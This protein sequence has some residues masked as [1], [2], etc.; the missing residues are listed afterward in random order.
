MGSSILDI[1]AWAQTLLFRS[2]YQGAFGFKFHHHSQNTST[3][4]STRWMMGCQAFFACLNGDLGIDRMGSVFCLT[5]G[6]SRRTR[7]LRL[8]DWKGRS[9]KGSRAA[10]RAA[11]TS[12][13]L[14]SRYR[15]LFGSSAWATSAQCDYATVSI[16]LLRGFWGQGDSS[17]S[18]SG[19]YG[20]SFHLA[21]KILF[22]S[23]LRTSVSRSMRTACS[24][25]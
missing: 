17:T 6:L 24:I 23:S 15:G 18:L 11:P 3:L 20:T 2:R 5:R 21:I 16:S 22:G 9:R 10:T 14:S 7:N 12:V 8:E 1:H 4:N 19:S 25:S 13:L